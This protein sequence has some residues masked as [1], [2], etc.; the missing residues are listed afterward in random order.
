MTQI[1]SADRWTTK[2]GGSFMNN[3]A[4]TPSDVTIYKPALQALHIGT[5]GNVTYVNRNG[6]IRTL[7]AAEGWNFID[8]VKVLASTAASGI[9]GHW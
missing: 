2:P 3:I 7:V 9:T 8:V 4:V 6:D 5:P 1:N